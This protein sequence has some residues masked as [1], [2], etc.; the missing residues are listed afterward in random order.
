M[1]FTSI[2]ELSVFYVLRSAKG[3]LESSRTSKEKMYSISFSSLEIHGL[4]VEIHES[5]CHGNCEKT[6]TLGIIA[7]KSKPK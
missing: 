3:A 2:F 6:S 7:S 1:I 4:C 5:R